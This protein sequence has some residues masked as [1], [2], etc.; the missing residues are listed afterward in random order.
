MTMIVRR[1]TTRVPC[2]L[3]TRT[4][5]RESRNKAKRLIVGFNRSERSVKMTFRVH[6]RTIIAQ[7]YGFQAIIATAT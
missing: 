5:A 1:K 3:S 6:L 7:K 4:M 2:F